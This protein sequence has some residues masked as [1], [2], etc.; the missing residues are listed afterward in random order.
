MLRVHI[1]TACLFATIVC[2][3]CRSDS[4][5][6]KAPSPAGSAS[7]ASPATSPVAAAAVPASSA[8][9]TLRADD[10]KAL[11]WRSIG[12]ANMGGRVADVALA[13]GRSKTFFVATATGGLWKT[14]NGG[15]TF[16]PVF[17]KEATASI[18]SVVVADAP[19]DWPGWKDEPAP[20][21]TGKPSGGGEEKDRGKA[22]IVWVGTGEGNGRNSSS[23][24]RGVYRST[25]GGG[26]F[27]NVGLADS[28]DIPR[29]AVDPKNPDVC[30]AAALGH[31]WGPNAERG[32]Y[33]TRDGG[34]TWKAVLQIDADTGACDVILDPADSR[35][36]YA[37]MYMR[38]RTGWSFQSGGPKGGIFRSDDGGS[39]WKELAGGLP[40]QS[41]RI[42]LD[43]FAKDPRI[44]Y[45]VVESD[46]GGHGLDL[47]DDQSRAGGV[48]RSEDRGETW[49]RMSDR[50]PRA[51]YFSKVRVDPADDQRVY[52]LGFGLY[53]S[54][55][56]GR[57]WRANGATRPHGDLHAMAI[58]PA[59]PEHILLGTDGGMY[60][61]FDRAET[62]DYL[63]SMPLGEFYNIALDDS[64]PYR[65]AGG[66]QDNGSWVGPSANL[67]ETSGDK[68]GE[69]GGGLTSHDWDYYF[70][71]DGYHCAF[72]P[73]DPDVLFAEGQGGVVARVNL[74]TAVSRNVRPAPKEGQ[75]GYRF[76]WNSPYFVSPHVKKGEPTTLY[77][78]GNC[79]FRLLDG[80]D[81][82]ERISEDLSAR[83]VDRILTVGS[84]AE[85]YGTV[86]SL[87]ESP[88][89]AGTIWA[90]TD[91][92]RVHVTR[93]AGGSDRKSWT[94]VTP[95]EV[96][97]RY[98]S[99]IEASHHG[100][101][102]AYIAVD[103]HRLDDVEPYLLATEDGG[104]TWRS[105]AGDL[106]PGAP[107]LVVREDRANPKVLY[108]GTEIAIYVTIDGGAHWV[109]LNGGEA[110]ADG[111]LPTVAVDDIQQHPR[112]KDLVIATHGRSIWVL[113]D[114]SPLS[115]LDAKVLGSDLHL[116]AIAPAKPRVFRGR[117]GFWSERM[118]RA[119]NPPMGARIAYWLRERT[120]E[121]VQVAITDA[122]GSSVRQLT[123][124]GRAGM[125]RVVWDLQ[126]D[127]PQRL[128]DRD[129]DL[130]HK[131]FVPPGEYTVSVSFGKQK[132]TAKV[133]V[134]EPPPGV[135]R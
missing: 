95:K 107:V 2:S 31:L 126:P 102:T 34:K 90:G 62:W 133:T 8:D 59:D 73:T 51:F 54:D 101:D 81:R 27:A 9:R 55:D 86:V 1:R 56:G 16:A 29:L 46:D 17:D 110:G 88:L 124:S 13:P 40:A 36:V 127:E 96:G 4:G 111:S 87:A 123:G 100:K 63:D 121:K 115:E 19:P 35:I 48:F 109:R 57:H 120:D 97:G 114:A 117:E 67:R 39:T 134:L 68:P 132:A 118:F 105:I 93:D 3:A 125:N 41:G 30:F 119:A 74:K 21:D 60:R 72:D 92:G 106:P 20:S 44:V 38:R 24:G 28:R 45:A 49:T 131:I 50:T 47:G 65:V 129:A 135:V 79:V 14:T 7:P 26:T 22:K 103:G 77:L 84:A 10:L 89:A 52:L 5:G 116:F 76:N 32:V 85:T 82:W 25:D 75:S 78:G 58:D 61:S 104:K 98:V 99:R 23:W 43:V 42:G 83:D 80:G 64:D 91:D 130:G 128:P 18:G 122:K 69:P 66:L 53:V 33:L 37:A 108:A 11:A 70:D 112:E 6:T 12:P 71:A 94:D 15:T 113:D